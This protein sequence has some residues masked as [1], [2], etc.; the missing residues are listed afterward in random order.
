MIATLTILGC[1]NSTGVPAIG[2]YWGACDPE[3]PKNRRT[4]SSVHIQYKDTSLIIDTGPDFRNQINREDIRNIDGVFY[5]HCHGDHVNGIDELRVIRFRNKDMVPV[6][7]NQETLDDLHARFPYLFY[8][9]KSELYPA[10][11]ESRVLAP[12]QFGHLQHFKD[13]PFIPFEQDHGTINTL[14]YRFGDLGYSLDM[15]N[16]NDKAVNTLKG[17]KTWIVDGAGYTDSNN[18]VH[19]NLDTI[20]ALNEGIQAESIYISSLSLNMD[21]DRIKSEFP[22][23]MHSCYDGLKIEFDPSV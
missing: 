4:R 15:V 22:D 16:L 17:I 18:K 13:L 12:D 2:N 5:T 23:Y 3:N 14:G 6:Y 21:Y 19:A 9:G 8:G 20:M 10:V 11:I 1:G 7:A